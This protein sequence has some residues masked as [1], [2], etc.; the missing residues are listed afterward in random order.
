MMATTQSRS[1]SGWGWSEWTAWSGSCP[2]VTYGHHNDVMMVIM[3]SD[4]PQVCPR[5][6]QTRARYCS[7]LCGAGKVCILSEIFGGL[8][9]YFYLQPVDLSNCPELQPPEP[10]EAGTDNADNPFQK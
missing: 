10:G 2:Q 6:C 5:G 3:I 9:Q 1:T 4:H 7:G 8:S